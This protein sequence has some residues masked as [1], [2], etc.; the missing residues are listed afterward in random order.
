[1]Y[2]TILCAADTQYT[3]RGFDEWGKLK[4]SEKYG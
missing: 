1:M 2:K 3:V 4:V